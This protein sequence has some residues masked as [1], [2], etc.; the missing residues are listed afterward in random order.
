[1]MRNDED[2]DND[3]FCYTGRVSHINVKYYIQ[4]KRVNE[5]FVLHIKPGLRT[6]CITRHNASL[7]I[8]L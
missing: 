1:M 5:Q 3:I 8:L 7:R 6:K 4:N 2:P